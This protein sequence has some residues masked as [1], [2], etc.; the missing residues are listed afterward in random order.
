MDSYFLMQVNVVVCQS[1]V[2]D[3]PQLPI[4][5]TY[6]ARHCR[7]HI[8][9]SNYNAVILLLHPR[10]GRAGGAGAALCFCPRSCCAPNIGCA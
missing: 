6:Q 2:S 8:R 1:T 3:V 10:R 5:H 4:V 9:P 7:L